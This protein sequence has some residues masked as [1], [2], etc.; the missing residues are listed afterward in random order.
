MRQIKDHTFI[1]V[2]D[3]HVGSVFS[4]ISLNGC[5]FDNCSLSRQNNLAKRTI[6]RKVVADKC[7]FI[8]CQI[9]PAKFIDCHV[10]N[11]TSNDLSIFW[12]AVFKHVKVSGKL[13]SIKI[14]TK[15]TS[16]PE[17]N[18][19][20]L[21]DADRK[22][23]YQSI[24]WAL[25]LSEVKL[26]SFSCD[27]I[28]VRLFRLDHETQGAVILENLP[29]N[30]KNIVKDD[31]AW[32]PW[33]LHNLCLSNPEIVLITPLTRPKNVRDKFL[34]DLKELRQMGIVEPV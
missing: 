16:L 27:G 15:I 8:G 11:S 25:D 5:M 13:T 26:S 21:Y 18:V 28:P 31:N 24:D 34:N 3:V 29:T 19:Q 10:M 1:V 4:D 6:V 20:A 30:W 7:R 12:G 23:F 22:T 2:R 17:E 32:L 33:L 14:N 9:G